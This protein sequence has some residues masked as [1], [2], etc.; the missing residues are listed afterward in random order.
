MKRAWLVLVALLPLVM[1][2][3]PR[4]G[5]TGYR[6]PRSNYSYRTPKS[7]T[8]RAT[9]SYNPTGRTYRTGRTTNYGGQAGRT[10]NYGPRIPKSDY[11][12][13]KAATPVWTDRTTG[14]NYYFWQDY[15]GRIGGTFVPGKKSGGG[16]FD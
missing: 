15:S 10:T 3:K 1:W 8:P 12:N 14:G 2:G 11:R 9:R 13:R 7:Y 5:G 6:A 16:L 4:S